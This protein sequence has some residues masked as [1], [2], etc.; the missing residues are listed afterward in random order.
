MGEFFEFG[1]YADYVNKQLKD[2]VA[3]SEYLAE[4]M[5]NIRGYGGFGYSDSDLDETIGFSGTSGYKPSGVS[6]FSGVSGVSGF[7]G[8]YG[9]SGVSGCSQEYQNKNDKMRYD[10]TYIEPD[11]TMEEIYE[12]ANIRKKA[13]IPAKIPKLEQEVLN[14][15]IERYINSLFESNTPDQALE[16]A[17]LAEQRKREEISNREIYKYDKNIDIDEIGLKNQKKKPQ[18]DFTFREY[19]E[20]PREKHKGIFRMI[21]DAIFGKNKDKNEN[22][23]LRF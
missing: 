3:Y 8:V 5:N 19:V 21:L 14:S 13:H 15:G 6:G 12:L 2:V 7:S 22:V 17:K 23:N 10:N 11:M 1:E 18:K 20:E 16:K 4:S 9:V